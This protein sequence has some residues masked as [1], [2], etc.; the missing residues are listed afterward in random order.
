MSGALIACAW[1]CF[2]AAVFVV[3]YAPVVAA[4]LTIADVCCIAALVIMFTP[5]RGRK[6]Q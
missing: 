5:R 3:T 4:L 2:T 6:G 1:V